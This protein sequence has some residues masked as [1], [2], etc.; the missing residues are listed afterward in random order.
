MAKQIK[1]GD[2]VYVPVYRLETAVQPPFPILKARVTGLE[3]R[4]VTLDCPYGI[5]EKTVA[6]S[7]VQKDVGVLIIRIGDLLTE[8]TLLDP[9][10]GTISQFFKLL[11][12]D[13]QL[14]TYYIRTADELYDIYGAHSAAYTHIV[15][16]GHANA[17]DLSFALNRRE[18]SAQIVQRFQT[19]SNIEHEFIFLCCHSGDAQFA[20]PFSASPICRH[21]IAPFGPLHGAAAA[22]FT[23]ALFAYHFLDGMTLRV[24]FKNARESVSGGSVFRIWHDQEFEGKA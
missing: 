2:E 7:F 3:E 21:L 15:V 16:I 12:P 13:D 10:A 17:G 19:L 22:Q 20:K 6:K 4:S 5:G 8:T 23:Q 14:R 18:S 1:A 11:L 9:L 24:A